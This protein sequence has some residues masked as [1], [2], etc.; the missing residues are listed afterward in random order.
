MA[1]LRQ[2]LA[3]LADLVTIGLALVALL[4]WVASWPD[5]GVADALLL[6]GGVGYGLVRAMAGFAALTLASAFGAPPRTGTYAA[7]KGVLLGILIPFVLIYTLPF[8]AQVLGGLIL[9]GILFGTSLVAKQRY[10][11]NSGGDRR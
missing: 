11:A 7:I 8:V 5:P 9:V 6:I 4:V 10:R 1:K 3:T 2:D